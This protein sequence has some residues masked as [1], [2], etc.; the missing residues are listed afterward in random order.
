MVKKLNHSF[1]IRENEDAMALKDK[2]PT[3]NGS[4]SHIF[5]LSDHMYGTECLNIN[6][7]GDNILQIRVIA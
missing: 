2:A 5:G 4:W 1:K 7:C 3:K 6:A